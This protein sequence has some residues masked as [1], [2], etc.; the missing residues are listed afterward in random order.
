MTA[1][2]CAIQ[3]H[4]GDVF[5]RPLNNPVRLTGFVLLARRTRKAFG[6]FQRDRDFDSY[7]DVSAHYE[8]RPSLMVEPLADWGK[9]AIRLVEIPTEFEVNDNI[10]AFWVPDA[11]AGCRAQMQEFAY[12][13]HWGAL[14]PDPAIGSGAC[15]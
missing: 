14:P 4:D 11:K 8:R 1:T 9:G 6:L 12:R 7:Q 2:A 5:W 10:V 13:L 15:A 3:R